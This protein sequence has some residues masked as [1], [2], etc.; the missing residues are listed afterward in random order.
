MCIQFETIVKILTVV[1][2]LTVTKSYGQTNDC[3]TVYNYSQ[4]MP[5]YDKDIKGLSDYL[6][7][8]L[9]PIIRDCIKRD[10]EIIASLYIILSIDS[11]GKVIDATFPKDNLTLR[12]KDDLRAKLLTMTGWTAG[13]QDGQDV[14]CKFNWPISCLKWE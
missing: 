10:T 13:Q 12:C 4:V 8:E 9:V 2:L 7:R 11:S 1:L 6:I 3:D 14:C 5:K